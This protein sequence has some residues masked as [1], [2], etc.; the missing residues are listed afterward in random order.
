MF[1]SF[2][3]CSDFLEPE[4][5]SFFVDETFYSTQ[6]EVELAINGIYSQLA[7]DALYGWNFNIRLEA[8]TDE[9]YTNAGS[10]TRRNHVSQKRS[11]VNLVAR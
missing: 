7:T 8:G 5:R 10:N 1:Y 9:S 4:P 6:D 3:S 11:K 2:T